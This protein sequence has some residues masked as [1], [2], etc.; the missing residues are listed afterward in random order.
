MSLDLA[1]G[2]DGDGKGNKS[3]KNANR[4]E[5]TLKRVQGGFEQDQI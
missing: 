2:D 1:G 3:S 4:R 5:N